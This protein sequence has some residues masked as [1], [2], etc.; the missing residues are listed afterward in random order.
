MKS[1]IVIAAFTM[2]TYANIALAQ[3]VDVVLPESNKAAAD[4]NTTTSSTTEQYS[5]PTEPFTN[6]NE[7]NLFTSSA[8]VGASIYASKYMSIYNI[9]ISYS[10]K[11]G[12]FFKGKTDAYENLAIKAIIPMVRKNIEAMDMMTGNNTDYKTTGLGDVSVKVNYSLVIPKTFLSFSILA[13]LPT[14]KKDNQ[15]KDHNIPIGTGS[16]DVSISLFGSKKLNEKIN[17]HSSLGYDLRTKMKKDG[18]TYEY[19]DKINVMVG[20]DYFIKM[21]NVGADLNFASA[22]GTKLKEYSYES[23]GLTSLDV[24]PFIKINFQQ[25]MSATIYALVPA[26]S[27]WKELPSGGTMPDPDRKVKVGISFSYKFAKKSDS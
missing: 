7:L 14:A 12:L 3:Y 24:M 2:L 21:V 8:S 22:G 11:T 13:K 23:P 18:V 6:K 20:G 27:K 26:F 16:T 19:G 9:P 17:L 25:S 1:R 5:D 10:F 15:V 4:I